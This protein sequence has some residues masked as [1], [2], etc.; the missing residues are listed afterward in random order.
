MLTCSFPEDGVANSV[1]RKVCA[2]TYPGREVLYLVTNAGACVGCA[3]IVEMN[4]PT[5]CLAN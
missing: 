1:L 3:T 5:L 2:R 4:M